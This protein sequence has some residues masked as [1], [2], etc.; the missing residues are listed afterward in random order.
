MP[1]DQFAPG[2][3]RAFVV[4][5]EK[6]DC[7]NRP[8]CDLLLVAEGPDLVVDDVQNRART[9]GVF[10]EGVALDEIRHLTGAHVDLGGVLS[11]RVSLVLVRCA[12]ATSNDTTITN[13]PAKDR[14]VR[15]HLTP[16]RSGAKL[17]D[18]PTEAVI[19]KLLAGT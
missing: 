19:G 16:F 11:D 14:R 13:Q 2:A 17:L 1:V 7:D 12:H 5:V 9:I 10:V 15:V 8:R 4:G 3:Q 18:E 6:I